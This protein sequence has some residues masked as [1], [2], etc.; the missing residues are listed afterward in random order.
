MLPTD[1]LEQIKKVYPRRRNGQG[2]GEVKRLV[3]ALIKNGEAWTNILSAA[4]QYGD[5]CRATNE[6]YVRM[7]QTFFG[8]GEWWLED[9]DLPRDGSVKLTL[10]QEAEQHEITRQSGESDD[11]LRHRLGIAMTKDQYGI[12]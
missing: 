4:Q 12:S 11:A 10:D 1:W 3:P 5:Y 7:A 8:P 9:Y 6:Q 2:W